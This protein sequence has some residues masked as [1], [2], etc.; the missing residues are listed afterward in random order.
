LGAR[1]FR[2]YPTVSFGPNF[3]IVSTVTEQ[4]RSS[5]Y[6]DILRYIVDTEESE[7]LN[8]ICPPQLQKVEVESAVITTDVS[9]DAAVVNEYDDLFD[10]SFD[11]AEKE[12]TES[13]NVTESIADSQTL[14]TVTKQTTNYDT[15]R[16]YKNLIL[17]HSLKNHCIQRNVT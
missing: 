8:K 13:Q 15:H 7:D 3:A 9:L 16:S 5:K 2:G 11:P 12:E 6:V 4:E 17:K 14:A 10:E 1:L